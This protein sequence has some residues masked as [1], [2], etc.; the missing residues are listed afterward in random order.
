MRHFDHVIVGTGQATGTLLRGLIPT[1]ESI[2]VLEGGRLGGTCVNYGCTPTKTLV[3]SA[4]SLHQAR[5][6]AE[7]GFRVGE[8]SVDYQRV[9]E[10]MNT[11]RADSSDSLRSWIERTDSATLLR[12][13]ATFS[14][15]RT[16]RVEGEH[17]ETLTADRIYINVGTR[18]T[19]PDIAGLGTVP[20]I[21]N[22]G[23]LDLDVLPEH[24]I[25][26]GGGA[27]GVE[28]GQVYR[29]FGSAVT[30][31]QRENQLLP[32]EDQDVARAI[33][34]VLQTEGV[35]VHTGVE[36]RRVSG[37]V[38]AISVETAFGDHVTTLSGTHLL[39]ATG[40]RSNADRLN[41]EATSIRVDSRGFIEVDDRCRTGVP[42]IYAVGDV[43]GRGA[44]THTSVNDAQIVLDDLFGGSRT[45]SGRVQAY[46]VFCDPPLGRVG[47]TE[48]EALAS[49]R[50][51]LK[52]TRAMS[53]FN[54]AVEMGETQG[55]AKLIVD[56]T[57]DSIVSV[58]VLGPHGDEVANMLAATMSRGVTR[59]EL[60]RS[61]LIHPTV[62]EL[63]PWVLD[64]AKPLRG[65]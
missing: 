54:R 46:A 25:V 33:A 14:S 4:R 10:R 18:P 60:Q 2:A 38:G 39:V 50:P 49:G 47:V 20:W 51:L 23:L 41:L 59:G 24:L 63:M 35:R 42:G 21:D 16:I 61:V 13:W 1:E 56:A 27:V 12:G 9:R 44:F 62:S 6:G 40:R 43:N 15:D 22:A 3:A 11:I 45:L 28:L 57:T 19:V 36:V 52:A 48:R 8:V 37:A 58:A 29:R 31:L 17:R 55:F 26:L 30:L 32:E 5:R 64:E 53:R 65:P 34:E 7:F